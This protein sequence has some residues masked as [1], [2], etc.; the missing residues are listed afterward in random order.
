MG[1]QGTDEIRRQLDAVVSR[2]GMRAASMRRFPRYACF[3]PATLSVTER[4][5]D[6]AGAV[7]EI[8]RGG[9]RFR[10]AR[11]YILDRRGASVRLRLLGVDWTGTIVNVSP[12][13]YGI[14]LDALIDEEM[15]ETL[16]DIHEPEAGGPAAT[17]GANPVQG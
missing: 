17:G 5:Y 15:V 8:S 14:R 9:L 13:G 1:I 6:L 16:V 10:E 4:D 11:T 7:T 2:L 12:A 3:V